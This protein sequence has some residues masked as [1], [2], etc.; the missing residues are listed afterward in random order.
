MGVLQSVDG[1]SRLE[2]QDYSH[3]NKIFS[4]HATASVWGIGK[5]SAMPPLA[6]S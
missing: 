5:N 3:P 4:I 1:Q 2:Y 6:A